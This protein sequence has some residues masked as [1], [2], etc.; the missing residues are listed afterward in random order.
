MNTDFF[1]GL[2]SPE[3]TSLNLPHPV[4]GDPTGII[5]HGCTPDSKRYVELQAEYIKPVK[6]QKVTLE[7]GQQSIEIEAQKAKEQ[8]EMQEALLKATVSSITSDIPGNNWQ[9]TAENRKALLDDVRNQW[10]LEAWR[11]QL[12]DRS[13][14]WPEDAAGNSNSGP[15]ASD[16][17][18]SPM[19]ASPASVQTSTTTTDTLQGSATG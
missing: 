12:D 4:T 8:A 3:T 10:M 14:F 1:P 7:D 9:D 16:G 17:Q 15:D 11:K 13:K 6:K 19:G 5:F 2:S 18:T